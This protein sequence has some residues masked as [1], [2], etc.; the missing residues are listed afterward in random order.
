MST[1]CIIIICR[2][3]IY[4][5]IY[6]YLY[7]TRVTPTETCPDTRINPTGSGYPDRSGRGNPK[8]LCTPRDVR[9]SA[10]NRFLTTRVNPTVKIQV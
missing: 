7:A 3:D 4:I 2:A 6:I 8:V 5:Y 10:K 9:Y 1:I